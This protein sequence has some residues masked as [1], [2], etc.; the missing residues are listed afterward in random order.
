MLV[1]IGALVFLTANT[2]DDRQA[3]PTPTTT[4]SSAPAPAP[5]PDDPQAQA[6]AADQSLIG[7]ITALIGALTGL[8]LAV[9]GLIR[10]LRVRTPA[11]TPSPEE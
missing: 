10:I 1:A 4:D 6:G 9:T 5:E 3:S 8:I 11:G 7:Q 2:G